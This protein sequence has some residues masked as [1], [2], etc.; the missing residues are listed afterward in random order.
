MNYKVTILLYNILSSTKH[1]LFIMF[2]VF[3]CSSLMIVLFLLLVSCCV[4]VPCVFLY[5]Y[6]QKRK[7][8]YNIPFSVSKLSDLYQA[9]TSITV[10]DTSAPFLYPPKI[11]E[12]QR[13]SDVFKGYINGAL[14]LYELIARCLTRTETRKL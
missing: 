10:L 6:I 8:R 13:L 9:T 3:V 2:V 4:C 11:S 12:N 5:H 1:V 14:V 7:S